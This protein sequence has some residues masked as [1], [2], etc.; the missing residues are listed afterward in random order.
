MKAVF[1]EIRF[2][3]AGFHQGKNAVE[4]TKTDDSIVVIETVGSAVEAR[5]LDA[6]IELAS[7][8]LKAEF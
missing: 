7:S 1:V 6:Q 5:Y 3:S 4:I 8:N 2:A